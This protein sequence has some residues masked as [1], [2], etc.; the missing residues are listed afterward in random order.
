MLGQGA[1]GM[2]RE[3]IYNP[4]G[5]KVAIKIYDKYKIGANEKK[6]ITRENDIL[7]E[8]PP[9]PSIM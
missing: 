1:F 5:K 4:T 7:K 6:M 9:H 2:V 3:A 8:L